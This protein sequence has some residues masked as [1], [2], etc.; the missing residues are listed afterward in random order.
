MIYDAVIIGAGPAGLTAAIQLQMSGWNVAVIEKDAFPRDKVCGGFIGPEHKPTFRR[1]DILDELMQ[2]GTSAVANIC[3]GSAQGAFVKAPIVYEGKKDFGLAVSRRLLDWTLMKKALSLGAD[4]YKESFVTTVT[5]REGLHEITLHKRLE[6]STVTLSG[7]HL[8]CAGGSHRGK[9][10]S[11]RAP[12]FGVAANFK[13]VSDMEENV[14]LYFMDQAHLGINRFEHDET[15]ICYVVDQ[16]LFQAMDGD[17]QRIYI[18]MKQENPVLNRQLKSSRQVTH[19][20]ATSVF[21]PV[22]Y[23][24]FKDG[25]FFVG[26]AVGVINPVMGGGN[27]MALNSALL[28][29]GLMAQYNPQDFPAAVVAAAYENFW[30]KHY[31][32]RYRLSWWLGDAAHNRHLS[33]LGVRLFQCSHALLNKVFEHSHSVRPID[34]SLARL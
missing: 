17:M 2:Q 15:N 14:Y 34:V 19:W 27:S 13:D 31:L 29:A 7:R 8:I 32:A 28:L 5:T 33:D 4:L 22:E 1:W 20:K 12:M 25:M 30:K 11:D 24:F 16:K 21:K 6:R 26:D 23:R 18:K 3:L 9:A 10:S